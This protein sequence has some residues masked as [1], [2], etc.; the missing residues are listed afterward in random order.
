MSLRIFKALADKTRITILKN[1]EKRDICACEFARLTGKSQP[2]VSIHLS[3]LRKAGL[4]KTRRDG[5][6]IIYSLKD[7]RIKDLLKDAEMIGR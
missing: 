5:K 1:L 7:A 4:V 3:I 6:M 2:T